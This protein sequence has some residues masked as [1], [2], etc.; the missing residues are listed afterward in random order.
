MAGD[1]LWHKWYEQNP[2]MN[3]VSALEELRKIS[4]SEKMYDDDDEKGNG[5]KNK[6]LY[7]IR[8]GSLRFYEN[9]I[10]VAPNEYAPISDSIEIKDIADLKK[11]IIKKLLK[12]KLM[13]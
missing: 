9:K 3:I 4:T 12:N 5:E 13:G 10:Y 8:L 7:G 1:Y 2:W 6:G 11:I